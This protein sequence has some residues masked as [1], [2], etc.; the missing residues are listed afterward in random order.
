VHPKP[1]ATWRE[2]LFAWAIDKPF[3]AQALPPIL[4]AYLA[5]KA[6]SAQPVPEVPFQM[7]TALELDA[8]AWAQIARQ[9]GCQMLRMNLNTFARHGVFE[10]PGMTEI[11]AAKLR[12]P[13]A[14]AKARVFPYQLM[15]AYKA[16]NEGVPM[17]V[18][19]ALQDAM[20][21]ALANVP[22]LEGK[23]VICPDVSGSMRSVVT[24]QRGSASSAVRCIDVA[25]L[26]AAA[27]LR[28]NPPQ[29]V[30]CRL[31]TTS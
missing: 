31:K 25:A 21:H 15:A 10:L 19:E 13:V 17:D 5:Y 18:R 22:E 9:A 12:D 23:V 24:G 29:L 7:L 11:V 16:A 27:F 4:Q 28:K 14:V 3:E 30:C 20:E 26:V 8:Q 1:A 6:D 2:A